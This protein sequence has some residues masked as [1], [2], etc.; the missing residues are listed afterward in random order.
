MSRHSWPR[1]LV[2]EANAVIRIELPAWIDELL[3]RGERYETDEQKIGLA[4]EL[5]RQNVVRRTGGPFGAAV[6]AAGERRAAAQRRATLG[7]AAWI[8]S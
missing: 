3:A 1:A 4:I 7:S 6:F 8:S 2:S 5:A